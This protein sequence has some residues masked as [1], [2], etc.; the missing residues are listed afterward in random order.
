MGAEDFEGET[1]FEQQGQKQPGEQMGYKK[2]ET[3]PELWLFTQAG[4]D[5]EGSQRV[6]ATNEFLFLL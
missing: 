5:R 4:C 3:G 2:A 6:G 1:P